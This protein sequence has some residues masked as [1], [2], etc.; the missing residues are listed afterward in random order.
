[1]KKFLF[2]LCVGLPLGMLLA[3]ILRAWQE[4]IG[5]A[6][7]LDLREIPGDAA[8]DLAGLPPPDAQNRGVAGAPALVDRQA[9]EARQAA[10]AQ[11]EQTRLNG[12]TR[13]ELL[14]V[15]GIGPVL[16]D[17]ILAGRPYHSDHEVV[18][19]GIISEKVFDQL[20]RQVLQASGKSA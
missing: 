6:V 20:R 15:Y 9:Q 7:E 2:G 10:S 13:E 1:M 18:E 11:T 14:L 3:D 19:R 8:P 12:A 17:R 5:H 4:R 16:A